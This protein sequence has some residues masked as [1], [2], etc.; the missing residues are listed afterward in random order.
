MDRL[1]VSLANSGSLQQADPPNY[2]PTF[3]GSATLVYNMD[4][5]ADDNSTLRMLSDSILDNGSGKGDVRVLIPAS[6]F[7]NSYT[8]PHVYVFSA[9]GYTPPEGSGRNRIEFFTNDGFEEWS[10]RTPSDTPVPKINIVKVTTY[11]GTESD[12]QSIPEGE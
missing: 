8:T 5:G 7:A 4:V 10:V 6:L 1:I 11:D 2:D 3:G 12:N 9:F